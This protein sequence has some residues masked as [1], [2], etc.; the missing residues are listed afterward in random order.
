MLIFSI[1]FIGLGIW[2]IWFDILVVYKVLSVIFTLFVS[3]VLFYTFIYYMRSPKEVIKITNDEITIF[4]NKFNITYR[5]KDIEKVSFNFNVPYLTIAFTFSITKKNGENILVGLFV[6][7]KIK[8]YKF[9]K[10]IFIDNNIEII[11][12]FH[13]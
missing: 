3:V 6:A 4:K 8:L 10:E 11:R 13:R 2:S 5:I 9:M 12:T 1:L 7:K